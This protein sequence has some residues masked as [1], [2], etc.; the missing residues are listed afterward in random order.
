[1]D[2]IEIIL[3][4]VSITI[5]LSTS[6]IFDTPKML[7]LKRLPTGGPLEHNIS[8]LLFCSQCIGFWVG[9]IFSI[10]YFAN[11]GI[12]NIIMLPIVVSTISAVLAS[13]INKNY[14]DL[15]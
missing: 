13:I 3:Y 5:F 4:S 12:I 8:T 7:I 2:F 1:V 10:I 9:L 11:F 6:T 15:P 14:T